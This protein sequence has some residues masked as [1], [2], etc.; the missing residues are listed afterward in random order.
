MY[1]AI[2]TCFI[3]CFGIIYNGILAVF[4]LGYA[5]G[6]ITMILL[7]SAGI[8]VIFNFDDFLFGYYVEGEHK[9]EFDESVEQKIKYIWYWRTTFFILL[10]VISMIT[11]QGFS[12]NANQGENEFKKLVHEN[13]EITLRILL[14]LGICVYVHL[15]N[16]VQT[17]F[18][19][20]G[21]CFPSLI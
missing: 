10:F 3:R 9:F 14:G 11:F 4:Y 21:D 15:L 20:F 2:L 16:D 8:L 7:T 17:H 5:K 12:I 1:V 6:S 13:F 18:K 19:E